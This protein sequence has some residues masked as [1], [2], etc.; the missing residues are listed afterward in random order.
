MLKNRNLE[1]KNLR[2][3]IYDVRFVMQEARAQNTGSKGGLS[4]ANLPFY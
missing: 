3:G 4:G 1:L 2:F